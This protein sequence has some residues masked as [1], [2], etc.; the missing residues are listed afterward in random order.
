MPESPA[1]RAIW[2]DLR[3]RMY[4]ALKL[5]PG[6]TDPKNPVEIRV[7]GCSRA[8]MRKL[9]PDEVQRWDLCV[10]AW[11]TEEVL[12]AA[13]NQ[14]D[15]LLEAHGQALDQEAAPPEPVP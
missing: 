8:V 7:R 10:P 4:R 9:S 14:E 6:L 2:N 15:S 5:P 13:Y 12:V 11:L 3:R 1:K